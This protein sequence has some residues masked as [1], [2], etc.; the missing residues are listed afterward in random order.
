MLQKHSGLSK[1]ST[2][3]LLACPLMSCCYLNESTRYKSGVLSYL[4][5][6]LA[7]IYLECPFRK[8]GVGGGRRV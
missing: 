4:I 7:K 1:K 2:D 3:N 5:M 6:F 8:M